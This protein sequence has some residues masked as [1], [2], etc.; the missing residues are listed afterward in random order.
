[1]RRPT[2]SVNGHEFGGGSSRGE[3]PRAHGPSAQL[4]LDGV[5]ASYIHDISERHAPAPVTG[6]RM[7][8][9]DGEEL[10]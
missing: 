10:A 6:R 1:M 2:P 9:R 5:V 7:P 4:I 3:W 8:P